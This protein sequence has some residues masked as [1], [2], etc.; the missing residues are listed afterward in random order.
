MTSDDELSKVVKQIL[1]E[2]RNAS[3]MA[4][5][6]NLLKAQQAKNIETE[7]RTLVSQLLALSDVLGLEDFNAIIDTFVSTEPEA[8]VS[9]KKEIVVDENF[10]F[11]STLEETISLVL[12]MYNFTQNKGYNHN[13]DDY[14][15]ALSFVRGQTYALTITPA[16]DHKLA[17]IKQVAFSGQEL[18]SKVDNFLA[19]MLAAYNKNK[20][21]TAKDMN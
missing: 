16:N 19:I 20:K 6:Q 17:I 14:R 4:E 1:T 11:E 18:I 12:N 5:K 7:I 10:D 2:T 21:L 9:S 3:T 13:I 15:I 8:T